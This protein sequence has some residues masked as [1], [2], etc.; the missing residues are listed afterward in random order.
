MTYF[1]KRSGSILQEVE[2]LDRR[3]LF[4]AININITLII[5]GNVLAGN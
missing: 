2:D 1:Y 5:Y 3:P 4:I